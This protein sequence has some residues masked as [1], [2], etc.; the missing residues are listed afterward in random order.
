MVLMCSPENDE[1]DFTR[2]EK[3]LL[4]LPQKEP[5]VAKTLP[6]FTPVQVLSPREAIFSPAETVAVEKSEGRILAAPT[7]SCPPAVPLLMSGERIDAD[8]ITLLRY[9]GYRT[10]RVVRES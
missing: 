5:I 9:Y 7:V 4:A 8:A 2:L 1:Q 3:I 10:V 6:V